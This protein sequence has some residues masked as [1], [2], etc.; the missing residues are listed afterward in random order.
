MDVRVDAAGGDDHAFAGNDLG[1]GTDDDIHARLDVGI[2][3][4]AESRNPAAFDPEIAFDDAP[5]IDD[6]CIGDHRV[7][8]FPGHALALTHA[9]ANHLAAAELHFLAIDW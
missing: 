6:E 7:G 3:G 8:A 4:F 2:A 1:A 5:P 9:I